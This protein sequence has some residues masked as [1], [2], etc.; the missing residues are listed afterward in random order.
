MKKPGKG[1]QRQ[2]N[3]T[4]KREGK[5]RQGRASSKSNSLTA[6]P[7]G[8]GFKYAVKIPRS[9]LSPHEFRHMQAAARGPLGEAWTALIADTAKLSVRFGI[10]P[11]SSPE[12]EPFVAALESIPAIAPPVQALKLIQAVV[13][14]SRQMEDFSPSQV[15]RLT[16]HIHQWATRQ[17]LAALPWDFVVVLCDKLVY[18][19]LVYESERSDADWELAEHCART[20]LSLLGQHAPDD[21]HLPDAID[22]LGTVLLNRRNINRVPRLVEAESLFK[23]NLEVAPRFKSYHEQKRALLNLGILNHE[24]ARQEPSRIFIAVDYYDELERLNKEHEPEDHMFGLLWTNRAW[25]LIELPRDRQPD[26]FRRAIV[27]AE[28]AVS[29]YRTKYLRPAGLALALMYLGLAQSQLDEYEHTQHEAVL[30]SL[31]EAQAVFRQLR[32]ADGYSRVVH[33]L[34]LHWM[35]V[36][37]PKKALGYYSEALKFRQ[38]QAIEEWETL[39]NI[40][41]VRVQPEMPPFGS[42][43]GDSDLLD[44][45]EY[46]SQQLSG[47]G[48]ADR[49]LRAHYYG[50]QLLGHAAGSKVDE[51]IF[52]WAER[53]IAQAESAWKATAG[54]PLVRY[55]LGRWLGTFYAARML[56]GIRRRES[57][58]ALLRFAQNGKARTLMLERQ[59]ESVSPQLLVD[60]AALLKRLQQ[61]PETAFIEIGVSSLGT[62][63]LV[64]SL[65][66]DGALDVR[67]HAL[68]I[69]EEKLVGLLIKPGKGWQWHIEALR[70]AD[71]NSQL[72][73]LEACAAG[74]ERILGVLYERLLGPVIAGLRSQGV[75]HL[76]FAVHGPLAAFPLAAAWRTV[77]GE[78][79]YV[80]ED[81]RSISLS[82]S[83]T[84]F[85]Y[86][87][88]PRPLTACQYIIGDTRTLPKE[89]G[90]DGLHLESIWRRSAQA[91]PWAKSPAPE[92][93][94]RSLE[95]ADLVH[96]VCHGE[97]D[98]WRLDKSGIQ[99]GGDALL[100]CERLLTDPNPKRT[101]M[102]VLCA[103]R[104][105]R[106]R[107]EDF[108]AEWLGLSGIL[109]RRGV[110]SVLAALWDVD[111]SASFR[112]SS[113]FYEHLFDRRLPAAVAASV[114][115][116]DMLH[117]GRAAKQ[118]DADHWFLEGHDVQS[119]PRLRRL[120]D[121]PWLWACMQLVNVACGASSPA[122]TERPG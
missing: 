30:R 100:S 19:F 96:A 72:D 29:L 114:A 2:R 95:Q 4:R 14:N 9:I 80:I 50:L 59:G 78:L 26:G 93:F 94:L 70:N 8:S 18:A 64:A 20:A 15:R 48:D 12:R 31:G 28:K 11:L 75:E 118:S 54:D 74:M 105:G 88:Q 23:R 67:T 57:V 89:A 111:Y 86:A 101:A 61:T 56:I 43:A 45:L 120:L 38:G 107:S 117:A 6:A 99:V 69:S 13:N 79:R 97:F 73:K 68:D 33:N 109:L 60:S 34:G 24:L 122:R 7:E 62:A 53:A 47:H 106:S 51:S 17:N 66:R 44:R 98:P 1:K 81:F 119:I 121:S 83:I 10:S 76:V 35:H 3:N 55:H 110:Q 41:D 85:V 5:P 58:D 63:V 91:V 90:R 103:C 42:E 49:A 92:E 36:G 87:E 104:S 71:N 77:D 84:S 112:I 40:V 21:H 32:I 25:A 116:R 46:L 27:D 39:G 52:R 113:A 37:E 82:P 102:V 16:T 65:T 108:G 115:M 22:Q